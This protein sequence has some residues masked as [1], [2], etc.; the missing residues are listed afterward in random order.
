MAVA[1]APTDLKAPREAFEELVRRAPADPPARSSQDRGLVFTPTSIAFDY[2]QESDGSWAA[3]SDLLGV[4]AVADSEATLFVE[5][6]E[7]VEE[8]WSILNERFT[9]LSPDLQ[10]LLQLRHLGLSFNKT[11]E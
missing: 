3:H 9:T 6:A 4:N 11:A 1:N 8:F 10:S 2:W 5:V 7:Q